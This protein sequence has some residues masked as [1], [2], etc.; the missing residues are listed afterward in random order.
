MSGKPKLAILHAGLGLVNRGVE[1]VLVTLADHLSAAYDVTVFGSR[2]SSDLAIIPLA[3]V[4][5]DS[6]RYNALYESDIYLKRVLTRLHLTPMEM[7][8][9]TFSLS[10]MPELLATRFDASLIGTGYWGA[11]LG[12][13]TRALVGTPVICRSGGWK[14]S[15]LEA[16]RLRPDVHIT[17]NPEVAVFL[18]ERFPDDRITNIP[19][20]VDLDIFAPAESGLAFELERP[21]FLCVGAFEQV[22]RMELAIEAVSRLD[23][24]SL[25]LVGSGERESELAELGRKRLGPGKFHLTSAPFAEMHRYYNFCNV[26]TLPSERE[27]FGLVYLEAM[28]C[29][30][31]AVSQDDVVR[32]GILGDAGYVCE[33][34]DIDRYAETLLKAATDT[35]KVA[36]RTQAER[37]SWT[38]VASRY[39]E[40]INW[41]LSH[42]T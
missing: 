27:S 26:F 2:A 31:V 18:Q 41:S 11:S 16:A 12:R 23:R 13:L 35:P 19:N 22:K 42:R 33:C 10:A 6:A 40:E 1:R 32:S 28:A 39:I 30:K 7:E 37:Y 38:H 20:G 29:G 36:P 3:T 17:D 34:T 8:K 14:M 4:T 24:G 21:V 25:L 9:L 5:R 15:S